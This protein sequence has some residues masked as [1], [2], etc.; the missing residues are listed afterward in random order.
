M[1]SKLVTF[2][3][4]LFELL[5]LLRMAVNNLRYIAIM[6]FLSIFK[7]IEVE[8]CRYAKFLIKRFIGQKIKLID[9]SETE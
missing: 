3:I 4:N 1:L 9:E 7:A 5:V 6:A 2:C 8:E